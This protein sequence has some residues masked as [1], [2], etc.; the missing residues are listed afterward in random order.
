MRPVVVQDIES[1]A[2]VVYQEALLQAMGVR[3]FCIIPLQLLDNSRGTLNVYR[4]TGPFS[5]AEIAELTDLAQLLVR[6]DE[7]IRDRVAFSLIEKVSSI[8]GAPRS[9]DVR[10]P[11]QSVCDSVK[12]SIGCLEVSAFLKAPG[13]KKAYDLLA[14]SMD[15]GVEQKRYKGLAREG[16]TG[17][18]LEHGQPMIIRDLRHIASEASL[19]RR[20]YPGFSYQPR[21]LDK[22]RDVLGLRL[23]EHLPPLCFMAVP[24]ALGTNVQGAIRCC[25]AIN[26]EGPY[27][28][29]K[30][31]LKLLTQVAHHL[32]QYWG[33]HLSR[34]GANEENRSWRE[35]M[36]SVSTLNQF[37]HQQLVS[38]QPDEMKIFARA[39]EV[40]RGVIPNADIMDVRLLDADKKH[41]HFAETFG[42]PWQEGTRADIEQRKQKTFPVGGDSAA[43]HVLATKKVY[44]VKDTS[45]DPHYTETFPNTQ[46]L[47]VAPVALADEFYGVIDIR[48]TTTKGFPPHTERIAELIGAQL[49]LYH[50]L[51]STMQ[52]MHRAQAE[53]KKSIQEQSQAHLDL[54][55]QSKTPIVQAHA[56]ISELIEETTDEASRKLLLPIRGLTAKAKRVVENFGMFARLARNEPIEFSPQRLYA[57]QVI[58][59]TIE[60]AADHEFFADPTHPVHFDVE[61][62]GFEVLG[63]RHVEADPGLIEQAVN[64]LLDNALKY[65]F[66]N[67]TV[68]IYGGLTHTQRF[69]ISV[70]SR[71]IRIHAGEV[72][73]IG[74]RHYRSSEAQAV[75]GDGAGIGLWIVKNIMTRHGGELVVVPTTHAGDTEMKLVFQH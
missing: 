16:L 31:E 50:F 34:L 19:L 42:K 54:R 74:Q 52:Q 51:A 73:M 24:I 62:S 4:N 9:S 64:N 44:E 3:Q 55:H 57:D 26:R 59:M 75:S 46:G 14:I 5:G 47:I 70:M 66:S 8:L 61:R 58:R 1:E 36:Q 69:H 29:E 63:R 21:E 33:R 65:S 48:R 13:K 18:V 67:T 12:K 20:K 72:R 45:N 53:L 37:V 30:R 11:I 7:T 6:L 56:R 71:G 35:L 27:Y 60:A 28:F 10:G 39:L 25:I 22:V 41:F 2:S 68:R 38:Q 32:G 15:T 17:W 43:A 23:N 49:G 40:T